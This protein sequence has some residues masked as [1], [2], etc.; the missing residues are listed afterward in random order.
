MKELKIPSMTDERGYLF[1]FTNLENNYK[2]INI[3]HSKKGTVRG[4]HYHKIL[5]EKFFIIE[6]V[7]EIYIKNLK[8]NEEKKFQ[9]SNN[10]FF[11]V[12]PYEYH[13]LRFIEN[14]TI[15]SFY[16]D[17]FDPENPDIYQL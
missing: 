4:N 7:A 2:Q 11:K 1:E 14:S 16:S 5:K 10:E 9:C 3:L 6:G 13:T 15:L 17:V 12:E 8:T